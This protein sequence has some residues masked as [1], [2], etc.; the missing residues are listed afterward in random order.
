MFLM[1]AISGVNVL[2]FTH[3]Y[4]EAGDQGFNRR[5]LRVRYTLERIG[6][7]IFATNLCVALIS[8]PLLLCKFYFFNA[9]GAIT[10]VAVVMNMIFT[11]IFYPS[12]LLLLGPEYESWNMEGLLGRTRWARKHAR[13]S[14]RS[15]KKLGSLKMN[16]VNSDY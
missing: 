9:A 11:L 5:D 4:Q 3:V 8:V 16:P 6:G 7:T 2:H 13:L 1:I 15:D 10:L 12:L 14:V